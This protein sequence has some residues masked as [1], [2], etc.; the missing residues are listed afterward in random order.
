MD[1]ERRKEE[2]N[3]GVSQVMTRSK[4][5]VRVWRSLSGSVQVALSSGLQERDGCNQLRP[6]RGQKEQGFYCSL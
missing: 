5:N 2:E 6:A 3:S 1:W 4:R